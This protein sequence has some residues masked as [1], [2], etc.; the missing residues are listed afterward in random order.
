MTVTHRTGRYDIVFDT[1]QSALDSISG[2]IFC[3]TDENVAQIYRASLPTAWQVLTVAAGEQSKSVGTWSMLLSEIASRRGS[4]SCTVVA[5]GGGV[6]GDLAGFV[7]A[8]YMRGVGL[9][10]IPTTLLAQVDS[11]VGGKVGIDLPEGK[12]L[13]GG[14]YPPREVYICSEVLSTLP[15][16]EMRCGMAEVWKYGFILDEALVKE[17]ATGDLPQE[18]MVRRCIELKRQVV[19]ADEL[20]ATGERAKLNFG[21]TVGHAIE[22]L[23]GYGPVLHGEAISVGMVVEAAVG[24]SIGLTERG[25]TQV[26]K[27]SLSSAGLPTTSLVL[28][29]TEMLIEAMRRDKKASGGRLAFSLL[30]RIGTCT[31]VQDVPESDVRAVLATI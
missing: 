19:E 15:E 28:R 12:N 16:R 11:S 26:V 24:E 4:R 10:Q 29:N 1:L 22:Q 31:L 30:K 27:D 20:E 13:V 25:T 18:Q 9:V 21:H 14:F 6:V 5:F 8:T 3:I 2:E 7:A 17:L 23:T